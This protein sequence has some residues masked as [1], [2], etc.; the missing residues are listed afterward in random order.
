MAVRIWKV[1]PSVV[2]NVRAVV[3]TDPWARNG[4][5]FRA[6]EAIGIDGPAYFL[7]VSAPDEFFAQHEAELRIEGVSE[8]K[9]VEFENV[10]RAIEAEEQSVAFGIGLFG[11][12]FE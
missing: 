1:E 4:Y 12:E 8:I 5:V 2:P 6:G 7:Y 11:K 9:S 3:E 10:K